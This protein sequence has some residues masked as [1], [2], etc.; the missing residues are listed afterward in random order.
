MS[1]LAR[2][3]V[4]ARINALLAEYEGPALK[5]ASEMATSGSAARDPGGYDGATSHPSGKADGKAGPANMGERAK[6]NEKDVKDKHAPA[7]DGVSPSEIGK[8]D[9]RQYS[10]GTTQSAVGED[11]KTEN[12]YKGSKDDPGTSHPASADKIG[13]KYASMD[14][15]AL[16]KE[17]FARLNG[18][19]A[20]IAQGEDVAN[21]TASRSDQTHVD[22][23]SA[24][25]A[26]YNLSSQLLAEQQS[27]DKLA[28]AQAVLTGV[29]K[30]ASADADAVAAFVIRRIELA[31]QQMEE[32]AAAPHYKSATGA[33]PMDPMGMGGMPVGGD[34]GMG[35]PM[36]VMPPGAM[37]PGSEPGVG[38]PPPGGEPGMGGPDGDH[39]AALAELYNALIEMGIPP[40]EI[41]AAAQQVGDNAAAGGL[42]PGTAAGG[43]PPKAGSASSPLVDR[44]AQN[45]AKRADHARILGRLS[46]D[47]IELRRRGKVN[48][49]A[50]VHGTTERAERDEIK[51]YI[52]EV[53]GVG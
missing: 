22:P 40:E 8:Q 9:Q 39:E 27:H 17:A 28:F 24:A 50:A 35:D 18:L 14:R 41:L 29:V 20:A 52:R 33:P 23:R 51:G 16:N 48:F 4:F 3:S 47:V 19:L 13:D 15:A 31:R 42:P 34:P 5:M 32:E 7:V 43:L 6:E 25:E 46:R 21:K 10:I 30:E 2:D 36:G 53:C 37:P 26:G 45:M 38:G 12:A 1:A 44:M 49:K 11:P